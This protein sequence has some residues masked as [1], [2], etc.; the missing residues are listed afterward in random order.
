MVA[1]IE[2]MID[3]CDGGVLGERNKANMDESELALTI[4]PQLHTPVTPALAIEAH[5][6]QKNYE[7]RKHDELTFG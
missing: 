3:R 2:R 5:L 4:T 1:M 6:L 7:N